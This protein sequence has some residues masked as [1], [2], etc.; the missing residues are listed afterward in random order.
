[1]TA[2]EKEFWKWFVRHEPELFALDH[3]EEDK[4]ERIFDE[5]ASELQKVDRE[6]SFEFGP[7][8]PR[9]EFVISASGI[10][11]AFPAVVSVVKAAP[12]LERWQLTAFRPRR[13]ILD[14]VGFRDKLIDPREVQFSLVDNGRFAGVY[15]FIPGIRDEDTDLKVIGYLLLDLALGEHDVETR[16]GL[17]KI[18]SLENH[19]PYNRH[20][21]AELPTHF[22]KL[23]S[24]LEGRS[25]QAS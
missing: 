18:L 21:L 9:R 20:P 23:V 15:L 22:D 1:M 2:R 5:L 7:R 25:G 14:V 3:E 13:P 19:T 6:L 10:K 4:R 17:I 16:L 24:R 12:N 11:S 8:G